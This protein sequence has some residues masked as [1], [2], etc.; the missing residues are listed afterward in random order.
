MNEFLAIKFLHVVGFAYWLGADLGVFYSSYFVSN[1]DLS[2]NV[3]VTTAKILFALDQAP[4]I[5]MTMTLPLGLH[6]LW[7]MNILRF[8][9]ATMTLIWLLCFAWLAMVITLHVAQPGRARTMLTRFDFWFRL[10]LA[11]GLIT[12][13]LS[14]IAADAISMPGWAALK[15]AIFGGLVGCGLV[16]RIKLKP[17]GPAF[18]NLDAGKVSDDD[19]EAI[20]KSLNG[21]RPFVIAIWIGLLAST[22]LGL[23]LF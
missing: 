5:C 3:R 16:V 4:R 7:R 15:I 9:A 23:H 8:D 13:G 1:A 6:L 19:N 20:R 22:A 12:I 2:R 17:F 10:T 11:L 18:A 14:A 21:T